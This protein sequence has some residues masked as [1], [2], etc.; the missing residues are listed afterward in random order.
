MKRAIPFLLA[1]LLAASA[2]AQEPEPNESADESKRVVLAA[3]YSPET[4]RLV[5]RDYEFVPPV[6]PYIGIRT[7]RGKMSLAWLPLMFI[8]PSASGLPVGRTLEPSVD[9]FALM[10]TQFPMTSKTWNER[11]LV[12]RLRKETD[13]YLRLDRERQKREGSD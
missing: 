2:A 9:P 12:R 11:G 13:T 1:I 4:L 10:G 5:F 8:L 7:R 3:D 6:Q